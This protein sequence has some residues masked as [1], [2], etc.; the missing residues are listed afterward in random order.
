M[1]REGNP[2]GFRFRARGVSAVQGRGVSV[3]LHRRQILKRS[4]L[5]KF[6]AP[7]NG[8]STIRPSEL[9]LRE[10]SGYVGTRLVEST[11]QPSNH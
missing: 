5:P 10:P 3:P 1:S 11:A 7:L 2:K 4:E 6:A 9:G 8:N